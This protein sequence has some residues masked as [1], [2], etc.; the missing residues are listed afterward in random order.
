MEKIFADIDIE[1][2][3]LSNDHEKLESFFIKILDSFLKDE[4]IHSSYL[5]SGV[6]GQGKTTFLYH[7]CK[8]SVEKGML[9]IFVIARDIFEI[10]NAN[11]YGEVKIEIDKIVTNLKNFLQAKDFPKYQEYIK[12]MSSES[13]EK[14]LDFYKKNYDNIS[15]FDKVIFIVDELED[16]YKKLKEKAGSDP[17]RT[18]LEGKSYLKILAL[19]PSG[20]HDLGGADESRLIKWNI[21]PVSIEYIRET[22]GFSTGKANALW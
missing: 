14:L 15:H 16:V 10:I 6:F 7:I 11:D 18:W 13:Q 21:P 8:K 12:S 19:T 9:P 17:L 22:T 5:I 4:E 20:I 1:W 3:P 2:K